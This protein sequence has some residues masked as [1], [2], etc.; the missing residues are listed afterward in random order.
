MSCGVLMYAHNNTEID[1]IRIA[2]ANALLVKYNLKVPVTLVTDK[3]TLE[4]GIK[5]LGNDFINLCF[6][7]IIIVNQDR[8]FTNKR[9][10]SDASTSKTLQFYN[11]NHWEAFYLSPYD[12]TL[13]IDADYLIMSSALANCWGNESDFLINSKIFDL[14]NVRDPYSRSID[15]FGIKMYWATVIYFKKTE[16]SKFIFDTVKHIQE[17][18]A[19]YKHLYYFAN[20]MY[21]NDHAFSIAIHMINGFTN[22]NT[23]VNELPITGLLMSWD[24][25]DIYKVNDINDITLYAEKPEKGQY[26][27]VRLKGQDVHIMNKWAINRVSA[28]LIDLYEREVK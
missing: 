22:N 4:W 11:C 15:D 17:N 28:N 3:W 23:S 24:T 7:Q 12:E 2:C 21:R 10:Y 14:G 13:F 1:Y 5:S 27:L 6:E 9:T 20:G 26:L 8:H 16:Y 19:Y 25:H 18:Y